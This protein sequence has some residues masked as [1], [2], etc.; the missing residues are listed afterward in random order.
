VA[1]SPTPPDPYLWALRALAARDLSGQELHT[2][3]T[4]RG[5]PPSEIE[6][7]LQRLADEGRLDDGRVAGTFAAAAV[8][9]RRWGPHRLRRTLE[10][11][12][13]ATDVAR[14]AVREAMADCDPRELV[15]LALARLRVSRDAPDAYAKAY[16]RLLRLGFDADDIHA[17][18]RDEGW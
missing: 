18:L 15:S 1:G 3:L 17:V 11:R 2:R 16:R 5:F 13:I 14:G 8:E 4:R 10:A 9:R 7:A 6:R 12:G